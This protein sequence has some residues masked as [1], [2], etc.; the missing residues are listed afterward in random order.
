MF[1]EYIYSYFKFEVK[2]II[3]YQLN[4]GPAAR[5]IASFGAHGHDQEERAYRNLIG[6]V[7]K[8]IVH[9]KVCTKL[10]LNMSSY[11]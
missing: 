8:R 6:H 11:F 1:N 10:R 2:P 4:K 3:G 5:S 7:V 9:K